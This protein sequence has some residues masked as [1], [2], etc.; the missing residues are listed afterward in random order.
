M[1][2][3]AQILVALVAVLL[4]LVL[5]VVNPELFSQKTTVSG[6]VGPDSTPPASAVQPKPTGPSQDVT[7]LVVLPEVVLRQQVP[8][9]AAETAIIGK[10]LQHN[11]RVVDQSQV[12][13]IRYNDQLLLALHGDPE[14]LKAMQALALEYDADILIL[15]EAFAEGPLPGVQGLQ[16]ARGRV[17]VKAIVSR[18]AQIVA[19]ESFTAGGADLTFNVAAKKSLQ[20]AGEV[21]G[22]RLASLLESRYGRQ[23]GAQGKVELILTSMPFDLY[24]LFKEQVRVLP[25]VM[26]IVADHYTDKQS[27]VTVG[28]DGELTHLLSQILAIDLRGHHLEVLTYSSTRVSFK[29]FNEPPILKAD[30]GVTDEDASLVLKPLENDMDPDGALDLTTLKVVAGPRNGTVSVNKSSGELTY[31]PRRDFYGMDEFTY[32]ICDNGLVVLCGRVTVTLTVNPVDDPPQANDDSASTTE[33]KSVV[34]AVLSNDS[35][36]DGD[37]ISLVSVSQ[38]ANGH[39]TVN[40]DGTVTYTP[41]PNFIGTDS[42]TYT[43]ASRGNETA[44]ARV[45]ISVERQELPI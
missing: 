15:G 41:K 19:A 40:A 39:V 7:L 32:E 17:E 5:V 44:T 30:T 45:T 16:S 23:T 27:Q 22:E 20:N 26:G 28:Y 34:I 42:F 1:N 25:G 8:D 38:P 12:Q 29:P 2:D 13:K 3:A 31:L 18:T 10:L 37:P 35:D 24:L 4:L 43:I 21:L 33:S 14:A 11:F 6:P 36:P 9:P